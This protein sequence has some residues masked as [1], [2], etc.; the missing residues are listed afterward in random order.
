MSNPQSD[1]RDAKPSCTCGYLARAADDPANPII[2][3]EQTSEYQFTYQEPDCEGRSMLVIYYCPFCGGAAPPPRR[4]LLFA[5]IPRDEEQRLAELLRPIETIQQALDTFG[6]PQMD[7]YS[8]IRDLHR[9]EPDHPPT[10]QRRPSLLYTALSDV[11]D[12]RITERPDGR[13]SWTLSGKC[14]GGGRQD[15]V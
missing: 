10:V 9:D 4:H 2:F 13:T 7:S 8:T 5:A 6:P 3:D 14:L 1:P 15:G 12:V 11:A